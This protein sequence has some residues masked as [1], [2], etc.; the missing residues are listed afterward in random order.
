MLPDP[1]SV[2]FVRGDATGLRLPA[3]PEALEQA[4]AAY[5]TEAFRAYGSIAAENSVARIIRCEPCHAGNSGQK[6]FLSVEYAQAEPGLHSE[7]FVKFSRHF[8]DAFRDRRRYEHEAEVRLAA[9]S[10]LPAFPVHVA[11]PY[12]ADF[13]HESGTGVLITQRI[14]FGEDGIEPLRPK[15]MDHELANPLEYYRATLTALARL[16]AAHKSGRLSPQADELFPFDAEAARAEMPIPWDQRQLREKV[17]AIGSF[18]ES[19][20]W[21]LL[22][23]ASAP[24]FIARLQ[25]D[26]LRFLEQEAAV[27][28]FLYAD[29][30]YVALTHWNTHIDN[31]W[32]WRDTSG[33]LQC[34]LLDWGMVRQMNF[35]IGL[36]GGLS[37]ASP[38]FLD[39]HLDELLALFVGELQ[40]SGG[41][42]LDVGELKLRFDLAVAIIGLALLMDAP[43]LV[44]SRL[45]D[46]ADASSLTDPL[47][48]RNQ[49][50]NGFL[51]TFAAFLNL[52]ARDDFGAS[53]DRMLERDL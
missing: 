26:A 14:A 44:Q 17:A 30:D 36:W 46:V 9:L 11:V 32:F 6:L 50:A 8:T 24:Q 13:N 47:L 23:D 12:F 49:V 1:E 31:A 25:H 27:R 28:R 3:H 33:V 35:A 38:E 7:L 29:P 43:A 10:R 21:L 5:L 45:P 19:C 41:P 53:L 51:H 39:G 2:D 34:G 48:R 37:G 4:G 16:A 15:N 40:A 18:I 20:P 52:W 42:R 22:G